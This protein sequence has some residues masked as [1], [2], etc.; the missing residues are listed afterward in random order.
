[1]FTPPPAT[2]CPVPIIGLTS[3]VGGTA[4]DAAAARSGAP[5]ASPVKAIATVAPAESSDLRKYPCREVV[6]DPP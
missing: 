5:A 4:D 3:D 2:A 6:I 1:M